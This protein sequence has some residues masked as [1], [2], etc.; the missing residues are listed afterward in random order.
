MIDANNNI[1]NSQQTRPV[2]VEW[3]RQVYFS[4]PEQ[5]LTLNIGDILFN[6]GSS[7]TRLFFVLEGRLVGYVNNEDGTAYQVFNCSAGQFV[8]LMS[9]FSGSFLAG[10]TVYA[11]EPTR[12]AYIENTQT[13]AFHESARS[14]FDQFLPAVIENIAYRREQERKVARE[15]DRAIRNLVETE[16]R[17]SLGQLA[18]G[19]A[20]ELNNAIAVLDRNASW[21]MNEISVLVEDYDDILKECFRVGI[22]TGRSLSSSQARK[23]AAQLVSELGMDNHMANKFGET[24]LDVE[25]IKR[26][27]QG[28]K[29]ELPAELQNKALR[30]WGV[31]ETLYSTKIA[32]RHATHVVK[33][34]RVLGSTN[35]ERSSGE[36]IRETIEEALLLLSNALREVNVKTEF[37]DIAPITCNTGE[38]VQ[39]WVNIIKNACESLVSTKTPNPTIWIRCWDD[40]SNVYVSIKD[41]GPGIPLDLQKTIFHPNVS[42]KAL[43]LSFGLGLGLSICERIVAS[44]NGEIS[45][46]SEFGSTVFTVRLSK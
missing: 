46:Q 27:K 45:L 29:R 5:I 37:V 31:G 17:A 44:Y 21:L 2:S 33:S 9:F 13:V 23:K 15:K 35:S 40:S 38:M 32:A 24:D 28:N 12:V 34:V 11:I 18:A 26:L 4:N 39:V 25:I 8:G 1:R 20:H 42:T 30:L 7:N 10:S 22:T 19:I 14:L 16:K 3:L 36:S 6:E 41:N 43:G